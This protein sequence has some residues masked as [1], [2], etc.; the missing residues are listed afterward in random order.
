[1]YSIKQLLEETFRLLNFLRTY[2]VTED[3]NKLTPHDIRESE[4]IL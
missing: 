4:S 2:Q 3:L 1:M